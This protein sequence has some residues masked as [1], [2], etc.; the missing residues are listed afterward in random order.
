MSDRFEIAQ[1]LRC[2]SWDL[3]MVIDP[4]KIEVRHGNQSHLYEVV[5]FGALVTVSVF[6]QF[7]EQPMSV[8][9]NGA[10]RKMLVAEGSRWQLEKPVLTKVSTVKGEIAFEV[11]DISDSRLMPIKPK[12]GFKE[13]DIDL[14]LPALMERMRKQT[15]KLNKL[16]DEY[17]NKANSQVLR[18]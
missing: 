10:P 2:K 17:A 3:C 12:G 16:A 8:T 7:P 4:P 1:G 5:P 15:E 11:T 13:D 14:S 18:L 6:R 9:V